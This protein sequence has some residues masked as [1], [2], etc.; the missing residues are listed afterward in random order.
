[1]FKP[2]TSTFG[3]RSAGLQTGEIEIDPTILGNFG[4]VVEVGKPLPETEVPLVH[5]EDDDLVIQLDT[6]ASRPAPVPTI[7]S[8]AMSRLQS[9]KPVNPEQEKQVLE[10]IATMTEPLR[11]VDQFVETLEAEHFK[12]LDDRWENIRLKGRALLESLPALEAEFADRLQACNES[13]ELKG[14]RKQDLQNHIEQRRKI[15]DFASAKEIAAADQRVE[16]SREAMASATQR[17]LKDMQAMA[18]V[19]SKIATTREKLAI[20]K[21]E[22]HRL[23]AE[24][25]GKRYFDPETGLSIEPLIHRANW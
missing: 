25:E 10:M 16:K 20:A 14:Q 21:T 7:L 12:A 5:A 13:G 2:L 3:S 4:S 18:A 23:Q 15:N 11:A 22:L 19:E 6:R 9:L 24:I 1:V 8:I 17:A